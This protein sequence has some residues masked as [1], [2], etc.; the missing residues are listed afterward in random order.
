MGFHS[1]WK[2]HL[3]FV[4]QQNW[5]QY[6]RGPQVL[7]Q[8]KRT[9]IECLKPWNRTKH[10]KIQRKKQQVVMP[11]HCQIAW[12]TCTARQVF[13]TCDCQPSD[14]QHTKAIPMSICETTTGM[15]TVLY[16][17]KQ[18][19]VKSNYSMLLWLWLPVCFRLVLHFHVW[20][21]YFLVCLSVSTSVCL[22]A[23]L[24]L[25]FSFP[26]QAI[27]NVDELSFTTHTHTHIMT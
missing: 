11:Q 7:T 4:F 12:L 15:D 1:L 3:A 9:Y 27:E 13:R 6:F 2:C 20:C 25:P 17:R 18:S 26:P 23:C 10:I 5:I 21:V 24:M 22:S 14:S 8:Q 16:G 19:F